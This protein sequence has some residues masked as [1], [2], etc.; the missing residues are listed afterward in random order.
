MKKFL[1]LVLTSLLYLN[2]SSQAGNGVLLNVEPIFTSIPDTAS[3]P[4]FFYGL[5]GFTELHELF[6]VTY[7][8]NTSISN[9]YIVNVPLSLSFVPSG[10]YKFNIRPQV[11]VGGDL[12]YSSLTT[13]SFTGLKFYGHAGL[14]LDYIFSNNLIINAGTKIYFNESFLQSTITKGFNSG[15]ISFFGGLGIKY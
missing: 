13:G 1:I 6:R 7:G 15:T 12:F 8:V 5:K 11:F 2:P 10:D 14:G 9:G 4:T 3:Q